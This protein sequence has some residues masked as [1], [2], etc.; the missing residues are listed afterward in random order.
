MAMSLVHSL[1]FADAE[2][3]EDLVRHEVPGHFSISIPGNFIQSSPPNPAVLLSL[4]SSQGFP[5]FN[6]V[7]NATRYDPRGMN[8]NVHSGRI[9]EEYR[10]IGL[11]DAIIVQIG[12]HRIAELDLP[13]VEIQYTLQTQ[14][15]RAAV[16]YV[17]GVTEHFI[18][19]YID[20]NATFESR[21]HLLNNLYNSLS[22]F[23]SQRLVEQSQEPTDTRTGKYWVYVSI[24]LLVGVIGIGIALAQ[25][26]SRDLTY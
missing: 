13:I 24:L 15:Y 19:T 16:A 8:L 14:I 22:I 18:L 6:V 23:P 12:S 3:K 20:T 10:K 4:R 21:R 9:L 26:K 1:S 11:T 2:R 7:V 17:P 25:K 5:S